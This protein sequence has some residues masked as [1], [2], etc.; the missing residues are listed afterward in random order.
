[1]DYRFFNDILAF[2]STSSSERSFSDWLVGALSD[3]FGK[4]C[5]E[6]IPTLS[7]YDV[8]DGTEN[9]LYCW[10]T[11]QLVY[12]THLDTVPP[13]I[14]PREY[15]DRFTGRG[16]CD[17]KGQ[18]FAMLSAC[19]ALAAEGR[20]GFALLLL[21]GEETGSWGA[22]A[23][24]K[25]SFRAPYLVV[26]EPTGN[27]MV[28]SSKGTKAFA[29]SFKGK[30]CH[31]GYPENGRSAVEAFVDFVEELRRKSF[32]LDPILGPTTWNIGR[33]E[34]D[35]PQNILSPLLT[36]RLYFRT[37][38]SSDSL[39]TEYMASKS[40]PELVVEPLGG[41]APLRYWTIEGFESAPASFG[42]DA[43]HLSNFLHKMILGAGSILS[44]HTPDEYVLK[45]DLEEVVEVYKNVYMSISKGR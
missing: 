12:C 27:K 43:P 28:S 42:S 8:A 26:G 1:M 9:L 13:Y 2:E 17:A 41:D 36:C 38:F 45:A 22:K 23:F 35:N 20:E 6:N 39:V 30:A 7:R 16:S 5:P 4:Y 32:P 14:A 40:S 19:A 15:P 44:A 34:S 21:S 11:P 3:F 29:L 37:T 33:L 25:T 18:L 31:S 24:A 10:G